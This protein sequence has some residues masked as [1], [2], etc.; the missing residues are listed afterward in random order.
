MSKFHPLNK[1]TVYLTITV[2]IILILVS[3]LTILGLNKWG[4]GDY[5]VIPTVVISV[6]C[7]IMASAI[8]SYLIDIQRE[9]D[10]FRKLV[11][12]IITSNAFLK[13][14]NDVQLSRLRSDAIAQL[15]S[16]GFPNMQKGLIDLDKEIFNVLKLPYYETFR[17]VIHWN[18][19][20]PFA[21]SGDQETSCIRKTH[22]LEYVLKSPLEEGEECTADI[23]IKKTLYCPSNVDIKQKLPEIIRI[24]R[25]TVNLDDTKNHHINKY[26]NMAYSTTDSNEYY[27]K[28]VN[29]HLP[30]GVILSKSGIALPQEGGKICEIE[31]ECNNTGKI[32]VHF[33]KEVRVIVEYDVR[34]PI[35]DVNYTNRLKYPAKSYRI[36]CYCKQDGMKFYGQ[37]FGTFTRQSRISMISREDLFTLESFEWLL[38]RNGAYII[39][40]K[41]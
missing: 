35:E 32:T 22:R 23:G 24:N 11:I 8:Y 5:N 27:N 12:S 29:I 28:C 31:E 20:E 41:N 1:R 38:P 26:L 37:L 2:S 15:N 10:D 18:Y 13:E 39:L 30:Q 6:A 4:Y 36:D 17:E 9:L 25:F 40:I 16:K 3:I 19:G 7:S 34:I 21:W 14:L 33:T